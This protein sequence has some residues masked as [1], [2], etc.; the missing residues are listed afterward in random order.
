M[1]VPFLDLSR[2]GRSD[3]RRARRARSHGC[4]TGA[5][6][7]SGPS[8]RGFEAAFAA[9]CGAAARGRRRLG[10]RRDRARAARG[11][12]RPGRR[13]DHGREHL[14]PD[15]RRDR[16]RR[17]DAGARRRRPED[18][19]ARPGAAASGGS[20]SARGRSSPSTSTGSAPTWTRSGARAAP[21][22]DGRRGRGAGARRRSRA[23]APARSATRPRSASTRRR[24]SARS[25]TAARSSPTTPRS[26]SGPACSRNY[27]ERSATTRCC[28]AGTAGS[29][30]SRRPSC[31]SSSPH[32]DAWNERRREL[33]A[34][35]LEALAGAPTRASPLEADGRRHVY[36]LFVVRSPNAMR[37]ARELDAAGDRHARP[38]PA[39]DAPPAGLPRGLQ[40]RTAVWPRVSGSRITW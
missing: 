5:G 7:C 9:Y 10:H 13:G 39:A 26:P 16:G 24:T 17:R 32:L 14:R 25:A 6:S 36:H 40:R 1:S 19:H 12:R 15:G 2:A 31:S 38:L 3:P 27:G 20:P 23:V 18:V 28:A 34:I 8:C 33:A 29:T 22:P 30:R 11:R 35:Y 21:R 4:S 37:S